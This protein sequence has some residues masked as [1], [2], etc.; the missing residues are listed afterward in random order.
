ML[1]I[2]P[3]LDAATAALPVQSQQQGMGEHSSSPPGQATA[4]HTKGC[5][6]CPWEKMEGF[7]TVISAA[8]PSFFTP[9]QENISTGRTVFHMERASSVE[10]STVHLQTSMC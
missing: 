8:L 10:Q 5:W 3:A 1:V 7:P 2:V 4:A 9:A 6:C